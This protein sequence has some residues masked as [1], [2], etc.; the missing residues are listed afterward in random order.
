LPGKGAAWFGS[1]M[2]LRSHPSRRSFA[3]IGLA[4]DFLR[5]W[6]A[7]GY[8]PYAVMLALDACICGYILL[9]AIIR[10]YPGIEYD[11]LLVTYRFGLIKRALIGELLSHVLDK[12]PL[13]AVYV[14]GGGVWLV[15]LAAFLLLVRR[16]FGLRRET[17]PLLAFT[18]GSP[19]LFKNFMLTVGYFDIFGFLWAI[20]AILLPA[21]ALYPFLIGVGAL[22][23]LLIHHLHA[24]LYLP[25]IAV[26]A[27]LRHR[28]EPFGA[29][30]LI[31]GG[32]MAFAS[33][34]LFLYLAFSGHPPVPSDTLLAAMREHASDAPDPGVMSIWYATISQE[35]ANTRAAFPQNLPGFAFYG[36]VLAFHTPLI[37]AGA[38][39]V[40]DL[41]RATDRRLVVAGMVAVTIGYVPIFVVVFDYA[42]W[43]ANW[44]ACMMLIGFAASLLPTRR[45]AGA[46]ALSVETPRLLGYAWLVTLVT[47]IGITRPF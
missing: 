41:T 44:A 36:A 26:I 9:D 12:V 46:S 16:C 43:V 17:L 21:N 25:A 5:R 39:V 2:L 7:R 24:L 40:R 28:G 4:P 15:A 47:R 11:Y 6:F 1:A 14:I 34:A 20:V 3:Q 19:F 8:R 32:A 22:V 38:R 42:R 18:A 33:A 30:S 37:R 23:L 27:V 45:P 10:R 35:M 31:A 13:S 29:T